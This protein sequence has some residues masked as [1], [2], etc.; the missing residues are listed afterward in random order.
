MSLG[1][2]RLRNTKH[3]ENGDNYV[4]TSFTVSVLHTPEHCYGVNNQAAVC[5]Q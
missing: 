3:E 2:K 4:V 5:R 1:F